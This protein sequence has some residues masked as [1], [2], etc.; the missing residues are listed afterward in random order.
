MD[1]TAVYEV[2]G[3]YFRRHP[4]TQFHFMVGTIG[5]SIAIDAIEPLHQFRQAG[6]ILEE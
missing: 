4:D 5:D 6:K 3:M 2:L 1:S